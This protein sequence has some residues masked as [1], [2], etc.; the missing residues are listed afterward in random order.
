MDKAQ[1]ITLWYLINHSDDFKD[2]NNLSE[3]IEQFN[4]I[5]ENVRSIIETS[6]S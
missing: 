3:Y 2:L 1:A 4:V 5:E 6:F